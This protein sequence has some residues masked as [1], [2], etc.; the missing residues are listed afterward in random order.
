MAS[1]LARRYADAAFQ[2]AR[3]RDRVEQRG[4]ALKRARAI[5]ADPRVSAVL[6]NPRAGISERTGLVDGLLAELSP[7]ARNLVRLLVTR[8][9]VHLLDDVVTEYAA[10]AEAASGVLRAV[11]TAA[12]PLDGAAAQRIQAALAGRFGQ[13]VRVEAVRDP[14]II[15]GL[16]IRVGDRV[17]D[18]SVRTHLQQLQ[19][20][21]A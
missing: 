1:V 19:A 18:D 11:V 13:S 6:T 20:A 14:G 8:G 4:A 15:G 21:M 12:V 9:R 2:V 5:I 7:P 16:V 17:I 10:M 3:D